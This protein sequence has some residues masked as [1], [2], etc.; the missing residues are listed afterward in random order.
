VSIRIRTEFDPAIEAKGYDKMRSRVEVML[1]N[2]Q[3]LVREAD[4]RYRGGPHNPLSD[5]ELI[6]KFTDCT[7][8]ILDQAT[9]EAIIEAVFKLEDLAD[10]GSLIDLAAG[11]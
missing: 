8:S 5:D 11:T 7:Q 3:K 2:G 1:T 4:E 6:E 9:R 10:V